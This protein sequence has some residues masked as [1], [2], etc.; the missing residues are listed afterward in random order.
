MIITLLESTPLRRAVSVD[1]KELTQPLSPL[2]SALTE[3]P[4]GGGVALLR[5]RRFRPSDV[6]ALHPS[7]LFSGHCALFGAT[8]AMQLFWNQFITHSFYRHGRV[9][10]QQAR[11][12]PGASLAKQT[13]RI[14]DTVS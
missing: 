2:E 11:Y 8:D 14:P 12:R 13:G 10:W 5:G 6:P 7:P 9:G 1:S 3:N 4:G